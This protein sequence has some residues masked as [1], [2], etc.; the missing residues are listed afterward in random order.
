M[1]SE[2][3]SDDELDTRNRGEL[4]RLERNGGLYAV[5]GVAFGVGAYVA[6]GV[7]RLAL[8]TLAALALLA[9]VWIGAWALGIRLLLR[10]ARRVP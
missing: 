5:A 7:R 3:T 4:R 1:G 9:A 6:S 8:A 10:M 2:P